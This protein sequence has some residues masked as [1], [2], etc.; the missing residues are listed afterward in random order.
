[1]KDEILEKRANEFR[2]KNGVALNDAIPLKSLL[3]KLDVLTVFK[4]LEG[5]I[6]GMAIRTI[7]NNIINR[8]ILVNSNKTQGNQHFT[9]CHELYHLYI[10]ENFTAQ[11][12]QTGRY[13]KG[14][15]EEYNAD[16][17]ASYLLLPEQG[18]KS[19]IP[20]DEF[21]KNKLKLSTI[22]K[23]EHFFCCSR[24]ALLYRL[25]ELKFID[26]SYYEEFS[27]NIIRGALETGYNIELYKSGNHNQVV[28]DY[29]PIARELFEKGK[30]SE[31]YYFSLLLDLGMNTDELE[32]LDGDVK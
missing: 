2:L 16:I 32:S 10:Q 21:G 6:S 24:T 23:I 8:F 28:G 1:M 25:K 5:N 17:F 11:V 30:I 20:D 15:R 31:S 9:I 29:G 27:T 22:L 14:D 19:L 26:S 4:P 3:Y 7:D 13:L 12:C 18:I